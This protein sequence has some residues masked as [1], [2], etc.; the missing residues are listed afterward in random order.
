MGLPLGREWLYADWFYDGFPGVAAGDYAMRGDRYKLLRYRGTEELYDLE[1]DPYEY[2]NL[3]TGE[4]SVE[5]EAAYRSLG[6]QI[7]ELRSS[8]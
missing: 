6:Q 5:E 2:D 7:Q 4:L 3:L 1:T 8:E